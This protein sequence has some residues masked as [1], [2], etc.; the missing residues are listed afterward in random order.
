MLYKF[1]TADVTISHCQIH[2]STA[3][4]WNFNFEEH[5]SFNHSI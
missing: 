3:F 5:D 4:N 1:V 2:V